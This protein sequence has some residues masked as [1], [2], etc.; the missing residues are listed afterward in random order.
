MLADMLASG[1]WPEWAAVERPRAVELEPPASSVDPHVVALALGARCPALFESGGT[2]R[3]REHVL[4]L[5]PRG[6]LTARAGR[7]TLRWEGL[8]AAVEVVGRRGLDLL[9]ALGAGLGLGSQPGAGGHAGG[10]ALVLGY[11]VV[12]EI[13]A[14]P[15]TTDDPDGW[16]WI[17][18][19]ACPA[20]LRWPLGGGPPTL[21][22]LPARAD[23]SG[24]PWGL[25]GAEVT[26]LEGCVRRAL[27]GGIGAEPAGGPVGPVIPLSTAGQYEA[28]VSR[29]QE[30]LRAG[31]IYQANVSQRFQVEWRGSALPLHRVLRRVDPS[32]MSGWF[33]GPGWELVSNS[34]ERLVRLTGTE[35]VTEP[36]AGTR[37]LPRGAATPPAE[38][39]AAREELLASVKDAAEHV[40]IVDIHR[41]DLGRVSAPGSVRVV[42][43][44]RIDRRAHVLQAVADI[45]GELAPGRDAL[46]VVEA[47]FPGGCITGVPKIRCMEILD[48]LESFRRGPYTGSM[49]LWSASGDLDLNVLIRTAWRVGSL[50]AF[51]AGGGVVLDS[52][53]STEHAESVA[54]ARA[55]HEAIAALAREA[56]DVGSTAGVLPSPHPR[57]ESGA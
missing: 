19:V 28:V 36:I 32:P 27:A 2:D 7:A 30:Y 48:E 22:W 57:R 10:L 42:D 54:K 20:A 8:S 4:P 56:Q 24:L 26:A 34:P 1:S 35:L 46:D 38:L 15:C 39:D 53:P 11:D 16:P 49:G 23:A 18:A 3:E 21:A 31:D 9:R 17:A 13:E 43:M 52:D 50:L 25:T 41:N 6:L 33:R 55:I 51:Q 12:H 40:M 5:V 44:H 47:M 37:P 14:L 45:R 29:V